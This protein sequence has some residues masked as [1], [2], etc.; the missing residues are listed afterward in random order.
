MIPSSHLCFQ[1]F[2]KPPFFP[3]IFILQ[4]HFCLAPFLL[5]S[6]FTL[7]LVVRFWMHR[8]ISKKI[9]S[10]HAF[11]VFPPISRF[12]VSV[13]F[14]VRILKVSYVVL[15]DVF[16]GA[17]EV[18]LEML[19]EDRC[20]WGGEIFGGALQVLLVAMRCCWEDGC[21]QRYFAGALE[22]KSFSRCLQVFFFSIF[23][24]KFSIGAMAHEA[25]SA[26]MDMVCHTC[27]ICTCII[28]CM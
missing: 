4:P 1:S 6:L 28:W 25:Y 22:E 12:R 5:H 16:V 23:F 26:F 24:I 15:N 14:E 27:G 17:L 7:H 18:Y 11:Q 19:L 9:T 3:R 2:H 21:S 13:G 10:P 20:Y 8:R